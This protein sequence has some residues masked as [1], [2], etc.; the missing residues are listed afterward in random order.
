MK[1]NL[2]SILILALLVVNLVLTGMIMFSTTGAMKQVS[3]VMGDLAKAL[4][5]ELEPGN[6]DEGEN[7]GEVSMADTET[8]ALKGGE[9]LEPVNL[10]PAEGETKPRY[11]IVAVS[12]SINKKH[13]DYSKMKSLIEPNEA[14]IISVINDAIGSYTYAQANT[15]EGK[16]A[17]KKDILKAIHELFGSE[18]IYDLDFSVYTAS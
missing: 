1:K 15:P 18:F 11:L 16:N 9:K 4:E 12:L 7:S 17:L 10:I 3:G 5:L 13:A 8:Y 2:M 6:G 14:R